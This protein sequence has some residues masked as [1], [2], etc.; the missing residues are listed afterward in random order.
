MASRL[1]K[2]PS[3]KGARK[4]AGPRCRAAQTSRSLRKERKTEAAPQRRPASLRAE[5]RAWRAT[6]PTPLERETLLMPEVIAE[7]VVAE[8]ERY[9]KAELPADFAERLTAK[10]H[11]L[12]A[13]HKH[14]HR[15][16]NRPGNRG[17]DALTMYMRHW[18]CGW[19]KRE[20]SALYRRLPWDYALGKPL[21]R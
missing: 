19:L 5:F 6:L 9:L 15:V 17:R 4:T 13:R 1:K 7:S 11:R 10:A 8:A 14:F 3:S 18:T 2:S 12:Y 21:P 16:L 20:R